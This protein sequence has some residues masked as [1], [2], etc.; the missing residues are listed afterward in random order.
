MDSIKRKRNRKLKDYAGIRFGRLVGVSLIKRDMTKENNHIWLFDCDCGSQKQA[1]IKSVRSGSTTSCGCVFREMVI[2]RN[3]THGMS[4][5]RAY[6]VWKD[7]RA[8]CNNPNNTDFHLYGGRGISVCE[9]WNDFSAFLCDM[10]ERP[11]GMSI[12]RINVDGDYTPE[13]CRWADAKT[14]A[15]NKRN[16]VVVEYCGE[17]LTLQEWEEKTGIKR[18]TIQYRL[19]A[20][21]SLDDALNRRPAASSSCIGGSK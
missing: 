11:D 4:K 10:G 13:N 9:R 15:N 20:G 8:R 14:Q 17:K 5:N 3:Q 16:N 12:D 2:K 6:R 19:K 18:E 7:M 1:R 21:W